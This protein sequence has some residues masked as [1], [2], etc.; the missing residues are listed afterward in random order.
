MVV[1][2]GGQYSD[3]HLIRVHRLYQVIPLDES[4]LGLCVLLLPLRHVHPV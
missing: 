1:F 4:V 2:D 3:L